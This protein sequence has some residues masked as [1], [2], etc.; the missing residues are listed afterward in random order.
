MNPS[1]DS[2]S[3][4]PKDA[5]PSIPAQAAK[6]AAPR[7]S[8]LWQAG[9]AV[10]AIVAALCVAVAVVIGVV[11]GL[12]AL[13]SSA[14][15]S[16]ENMASGELGAKRFT[17]EQISGGLFA[18]SKIVVVDVK[19]VISSGDGSYYEI[20]NSERI[21]ERLKAAAEDSS[22]KAVII[23][24][25]TPGGEVTASDEIHHRILKLRAKPSSKPV[26]AVMNSLAASGGYYVATACDK[27]VANRLTLT[28]SIGVIIE[29]YNY[30]ELF[31]KVGVQAEVYKSG[32]MKDMLNGARPRTPEEREIVQKLVDNTYAEFLTVVSK[33]RKIPMAKLKGSYL[34]DGRVLD[35]V[36]AKEAG[37][38]DSLGYFEDGVK[39]AASLAKITNYKVIRYS[40][41]F[42]LARLLENVSA[43]DMK[44]VKLDIG[45][46]D[47][48]APALRRGCLY[49]LPPSWN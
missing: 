7:N 34:T 31:K 48:Q 49:F 43:K 19:G 17:E 38:V 21:C 13:A 42:S 40:E 26:V 35:G 10:L 23:N 37:L 47:A 22:V 29:G 8:K 5:S 28:G 25:D 11:F 14:L 6:A 20:A 3:N 2:S 32:P 45:S 4:A 46:M 24:L 1:E 33:G 44:S 39:E 9:C 30:A 15:P 27:I 16:L 36:Q 41:P 18:S 12:A